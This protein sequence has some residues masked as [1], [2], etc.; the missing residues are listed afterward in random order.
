[1]PD[2]CNVAINSLLHNHLSSLT[3][4]HTQSFTIDGAGSCRPEESPVLR[5]DYMLQQMSAMGNGQVPKDVLA[6]ALNQPAA[7]FKTMRMSFRAVT[8]ELGPKTKLPASERFVMGASQPI[9]E[10]Y[11]DEKIQVAH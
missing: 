6:L 9:I 7:L 4:T 1:M 5:K 3:H 8:E 11:L 2:P 10:R